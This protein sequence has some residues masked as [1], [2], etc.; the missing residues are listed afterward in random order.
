[1]LNNLLKPF[2]LG[3]FLF[4]TGT[5]FAQI[6]I[7]SDLEQRG[8][9]AQVLIAH[10]DSLY[11]SQK[12]KTLPTPPLLRE[13]IRVMQAWQAI[14]EGKLR[15]HNELIH[16][17]PQGGKP[18]FEK[19]KLTEVMDQSSGLIWDFNK[20]PETVLSIGWENLPDSLDFEP[21]TAFSPNPFNFLI[22]DSLMKKLGYEGLKDSLEMREW[23]KLQASFFHG[24]GLPELFKKNHLKP[25][26]NTGRPNLE[27]RFGYGWYHG[28]SSDS[29][30]TFYRSQRLG[31]GTYLA[32]YVPEEN[33]HILFHSDQEI[34]PLQL[35]AL[36]NHWFEKSTGKSLVLKSEKDQE[37]LGV[38]A[39]L[40]ALSLLLIISTLRSKRL[41]KGFGASIFTTS[42]LVLLT[43]IL[44]GILYW[45]N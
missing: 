3:L 8:L 41:R 12:Q 18:W 33:F 29:L 22:L 20:N 6:K 11:A 35:E 4:L 37:L 38:I 15:L 1:M 42:I 14:A 24:E 13:Q 43:C 23:F 28:F 2:I 9:K 19:V 45:L 17:F 16:Y 34:E 26:V 30:A 10:G 44:L 21:G 31:S 39:L 32:L 40:A 25:R 5:G 36:S 7:D 27:A